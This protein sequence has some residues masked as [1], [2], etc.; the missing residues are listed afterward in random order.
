M[1]YFIIRYTLIMIYLF[2][3]LRKKM[4]KTNGQTQYL[5]VK[6]ITYFGTEE[7]QMK[8]QSQQDQ[9]YFKIQN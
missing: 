5:K 1:T 4:N 8:L 3:N 6:N 2:Y 7:V 9:E